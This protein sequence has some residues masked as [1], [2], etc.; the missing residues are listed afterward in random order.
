MGGHARAQSPVN[1]SPPAEPFQTPDEPPSPRAMRQALGA[2]LD[3]VTGARDVLAHLAAL[4]RILKTYGLA[5]LDR[6]PLPVLGRICAQLASL[7]VRE[8]DRPLQALRALL[9]SALEGRSP[10]HAASTAALVSAR[11]A[12]EAPVIG[13][14][15][16]SD[17]QRAAPGLDQR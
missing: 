2:L 14:A 4:E 3:Q 11:A 8:D 7:P 9:A 6:M 13:E 1:T 5:S 10:L 15:T 16:L 17:F 12:E